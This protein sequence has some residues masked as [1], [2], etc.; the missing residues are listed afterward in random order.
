MKRGIAL[1]LALLMLLSLLSGCGDANRSEAEPE[2]T[3]EETSEPGPE[4]TPDRSLSWSAAFRDDSLPEGALSPEE[5]AFYFTDEDGNSGVKNVLREDIRAWWNG[6]ETLPRTDYYEQFMPEALQELYPVLDYAIANSYSCFCVPTADFT[7]SDVAVGKKFLQWMYRINGNVISA[8]NCGSFDL[9]DGRTLQYILVTLRGMNIQGTRS[10]YQEAIA[11]AREIVAQIPE[12]SGDYDKIL[13]LYSWLTE[14]VVYYDVDDPYSYYNDDWNLLYD[15]LV[16]NRTVCAGYA[17]ALY[18]MCNLAGVEYFVVMGSLYDGQGWGGH[19][20]NV[21]K[22]DGEYYEFD[23]TW[24]VG[25]PPEWYNFF[26]LS[27]ESLQSVWARLVQEP[28]EEYR[29]PCTKDLPIPGAEAFPEDLEP[30]STEGNTYSQPFIDL[31]LS[32]D[33]SWT[34]YSR[35]EIVERYYGGTS[36]SMERT[37]RMGMPYVDLVLEKNGQLVQIMLEKVPVLTRS[38][39]LCESQKSYMDEIALLLPAELKAIGLSK[40]EATRFDREIGGRRYAGVSVSGSA[41]GSGY[42]QTFLC[43]ERNGIFLTISIVSYSEEQCGQIVDSLI[44]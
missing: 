6:Q 22:I 3:P 43:T 40:P 38:G 24:D 9:G 36:L 32:W 4:P 17:E 20:W 8:E 26:G 30:G 5:V 10:E 29:Q 31:T 16:K 37:L 21:A 1:L 39:M 2:Q 15:T 11:K 42:A 44:Q 34:V 7:P 14:N 18:V 13:F 41:G 19:A 12:G 25:N 28:S 23:S 27:D 33:D 35:E